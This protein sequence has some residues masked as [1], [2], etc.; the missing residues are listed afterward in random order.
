MR[1]NCI[2]RGW[3]IDFYQVYASITCCRVVGRRHVQRIVPYVALLQTT[4]LSLSSS[5]CRWLL[6]RW[7]VSW[8]LLEIGLFKNIYCEIRKFPLTIRTS[9]LFANILTIELRK[10]DCIGFSLVPHVDKDSKRKE[11]SRT[12]NDNYLMRSDGIS[13]FPFPRCWILAMSREEKK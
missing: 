6:A 10:F 9:A 2:S 12:N 8:R 1:K 11:Q 7:W 13:R 4:H 5:L 3:I